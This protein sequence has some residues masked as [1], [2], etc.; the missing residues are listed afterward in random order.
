[1]SDQV[2]E[3]EK[4]WYAQFADAQNGSRAEHTQRFKD[5]VLQQTWP[6]DILTDPP[7]DTGGSPGLPQSQKKLASQDAANKNRQPPKKVPWEVEQQRRE[8]RK[9][10]A[11]ADHER[12]LSQK[13]MIDA[14]YLLG[15]KFRKPTDP[16]WQKLAAWDD[17]TAAR[18]S[19][20][21]QRQKRPKKHMPDTS[22]E[23]TKNDVV[24]CPELPSRD[25]ASYPKKTADMYMCL[26]LD[27]PC[28]GD[29]KCKAS[30]H[31]CCREGLSRRDLEDAIK[32]KE[33][34]VCAKIEELAF[35]DGKLDKAHKTWD[36]WYSKSMRD[37]DSTRVKARAPPMD[38]TNDPRDAQARLI[39]EE[40]RGT[41]TEELQVVQAHNPSYSSDRA[42]V[43]LG[44]ALLPSAGLDMGLPSQCDQPN[45]SPDN[46]LLPC[47]GLDLGLPSE[48]DE[49]DFFMFE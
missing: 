44:N 7:L 20:Q 16:E 31:R 22:G 28:G 23:Q 35:R 1:M 18:K 24:P 32:R 21:P 48:W 13:D 49:D 40:P 17:Y 12:Y 39:Q 4:Q 37:L 38:W 2:A 15:N 41:E 26:H 34:R 27:M 10:K 8:E 47:A 43:S 30:A 46:A 9:K 6:V 3:K 19:K 42:N 25:L 5:I 45:A 14:Q 29:G 36:G 11:E 33:E